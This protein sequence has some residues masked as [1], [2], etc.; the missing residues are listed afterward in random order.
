MGNHKYM[1][2]KK[3]NHNLRLSLMS[4]IVTLQLKDEMFKKLKRTLFLKKSITKALK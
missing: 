3:R 2:I 1:Q 4:V